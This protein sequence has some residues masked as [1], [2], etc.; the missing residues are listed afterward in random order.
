MRKL[1]RHH[2]GGLEE[3]LATTVEVNDF[4][5]I[6]RIV[7]KEWGDYCSN[8]N[9]LYAGDDSNRIDEECKETYYVVADFKGGGQQQCIGMCN[10]ARPTPVMT[11]KMLL[12]KLEGIPDDIEIRI[13]PDWAND[14]DYLPIEGVGFVEKHNLILIQPKYTK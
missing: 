6:E 7:K 13:V 4:A 11:K 5:D 14:F 2:R 12:E 9:T 10:F 3:S 1:F 8:V